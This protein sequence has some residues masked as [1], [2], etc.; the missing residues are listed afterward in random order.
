MK[1]TIAVFTGSRAEYGLLYWLLKEIK[2]SQSLAL[3]LIV[4]GMHLSKEFGDTWRQIEADG[5][6]IDS[7]VEMLLSSDTPV[8]IAKS[9]GLGT[10]GLADSLQSLNPDLLIIL[11]DRF[12]AL[13]AAQVA[14]ILGIPIAH[15][16]G[17]EI[18]EGAYDDTI[19]HSI[20]KMASLHFVAA[21]PYRK[22]VIQMGEAPASVF[23]VGA[24]G[25]EH[26]L[27]TPRL[28][29]DELAQDLSFPLRKPFFIVTYHPVTLLDEDPRQS[30]DEILT[31][32]DHFPEYQVILTYPNADNG[33]RGLI[34]M[35]K[36]HARNNPERA[37]AIQSMGSKRYLSALAESAAVIGNSSSG[38]I[39]APSFGVPTVNIGTRQQGRL[40]AESV[41]HCAPH[42]Q[43]IAEC[44][45][46]ALSAQHVLLSSRK[47]NPYGQGRTAQEIARVLRSA[48]LSK[49]K[50]FFNL[51]HAY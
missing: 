40:A 36:E 32:L 24:L 48:D 14:M 18:T 41:L 31:A 42:A 27:R 34:P 35:L 17:G 15:M 43:S 3:Q 6:F 19:R 1:R 13:A 51:E 4:S 46:R 20:T 30:M 2:E 22:R 16:H 8:G 29:L 23:N 9:V 25:L 45:R 21:E 12:E 26:V 28:S 38:I 44:I 11:G 47:S 37:M 39:E 49:P 33:G 10:I 5:F 50:T 7:K